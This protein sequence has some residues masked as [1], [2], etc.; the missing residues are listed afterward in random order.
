MVP[1]WV[2]SFRGMVNS[3]EGSL[4][5]GLVPGP[6]WYKETDVRGMEAVEGRVI[7]AQFEE[8]AS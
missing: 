8:V 4:A 2:E 7:A 6:E 1:V 3:G 5:P